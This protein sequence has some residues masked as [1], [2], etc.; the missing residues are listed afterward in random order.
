MTIPK[1]ARKSPPP[2]SPPRRRR[3]SP[4]QRE[5]RKTRPKKEASVLRTAVVTGQSNAPLKI[6]VLKGITTKLKKA[7]VAGARAE[8]LVG[9][10]LDEGYAKVDRASF[11]VWVK[12]DVGMDEKQAYRLRAVGRV[13]RPLFEKGKVAQ[14]YLLEVGIS[15]LTTF[16]RFPK[17]LR[18]VEMSPGRISVRADDKSD[19]VPID[20]LTVA[21]LRDMLKAI[22]G[23]ERLGFQKAKRYLL[24]IEEKEFFI[25]F[26]GEK[27]KPEREKYIPVVQEWQSRAKKEYERAEKL[28]QEKHAEIKK[29]EWFLKM[30][31]GDYYDEDPE[32]AEAVTK[33]HESNADEALRKVSQAVTE[34]ART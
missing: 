4:P 29:T 15:R 24:E 8:L 28:V 21:K 3:V 9:I 25:Q 2:E 14:D 1:K 19:P 13:V 33:A 6:P 17:G 26:C 23:S 12:Q 27:L 34:A 16:V 11:R 10:L 18:Q 5:S 7:L 30:L 31:D 32:T 20:Q 22:K